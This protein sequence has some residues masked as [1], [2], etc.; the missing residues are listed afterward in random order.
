MY[1]YHYRKI[2]AFFTIFAVTH[3]GFAQ[4]ITPQEKILE[5]RLKTCDFEVSGTAHI[6][7]S[8][9]KSDDS[10]CQ[11][12]FDFEKFSFKFSKMQPGDGGL[13]IIIKKPESFYEQL[14]SSGFKKNNKNKWIFL[15]VGRLLSPRKFKKTSMIEI[16]E[17]YGFTLI[18]RQTEFGHIAQGGAIEMDSVH[19][20]REIPGYLIFE[21][22]A[23]EVGFPSNRIDELM[24]D[25]IKIVQSV[26]VKE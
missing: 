19:I 16:P 10:F 1:K 18:G 11:T 14:V 25:L 24:P 6:K 2:F 12:H 26:H 20:V 9:L 23:F 22:V 5:N 8:D 21:D 7:I 15:G 17:K 13:S 4:Q 3:V